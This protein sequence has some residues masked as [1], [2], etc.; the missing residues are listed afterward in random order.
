[1]SQVEQIHLTLTPEEITF[2]KV[3]MPVS[4]DAEGKIHAFTWASKQRAIIAAINGRTI[5]VHVQKGG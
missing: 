3:N 4:L 2:L 5:T 1:M